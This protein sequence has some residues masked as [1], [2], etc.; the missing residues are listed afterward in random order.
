MNH[1]TKPDEIY[2]KRCI[3][4]AMNGELYVRPNPM[5]GSVIVCNNKII[6]EG[7]HTKYGEAH[8]EVNAINSVKD[9]SLLPDSTLYVNLEPCSHYGKTPPCADL[10]I[11]NGI[12][13]VVIGNIDPH[14][15]VA[16]KGIEKLRNSGCDVTTGIL[17]DKCYKLNKAFFTFHIKKRPYIILKWAESADGYI[18]KIRKKDDPVGPNWITNEK[19]R[20]LVHKWRAECQAIMAGTKTILKDDPGLDVRYWKGINPVRIIIDKELK[21]ESNSAVFKNNATVL[22]FTQKQGI[23]VNNIQYITVESNEHILS[24]IMN[25]LYKRNIISLF[26]EGGARLLQSLIDAGLWDEA[27]VFRGEQF[28]EHGIQAPVI[29]EKF[30]YDNYVFNTQLIHMYPLETN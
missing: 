2:M 6:G 7:Y 5:V 30:Q 29:R 22:V 23:S 9:T 4:L 8:A 11:K 25:E 17:N 10:I 16:G 24:V 27:R 12:K 26:V 21:L 19:C 28:F 20:V 13:R 18:D 1:A 15:K 14:E 3:E